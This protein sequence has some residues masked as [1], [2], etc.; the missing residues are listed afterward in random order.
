MSGATPPQGLSCAVLSSNYCLC[1]TYLD[2]SK[3]P[4][5]RGVQA[6]KTTRNQ[7]NGGSADTPAPPFTIA[8]RKPERDEFIKDLPLAVRAV[9][10][11]SVHQ[12]QLLS[13]L[14]KASTVA[15]F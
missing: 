8:F 6:G 7:S 5:P 15:S 2:W 9:S 12:S 14:T 11:Q 3:S 13:Y 10:K 1:N 4:A